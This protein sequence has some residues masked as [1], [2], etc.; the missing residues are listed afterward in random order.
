MN[1]SVE[2]SIQGSL[3]GV[4]GPEYFVSDERRALTHEDAN[5]FQ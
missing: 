1:I 5:D 2:N 3:S 4:Q